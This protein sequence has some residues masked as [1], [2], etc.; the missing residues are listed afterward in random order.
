MPGAVKTVLVVDDTD[1]VR[2]V[3]EA[4]LQSLGFVTLGA[5]DGVVA[6]ELIRSV[7]PDVVLCDLRMPHMDGLELLAALRASHPDLPVIVMS[8]AGLLGDAIGALKLGAWDYVEKP[9]PALD[10]LEHA[11]ARA[12]ERAALL[13]E[14]RRQRDDLE[15]MNRELRATL[16]LLS[17]DEEAGRK[18]Q[19][20]L[21]PRNHVR[22][23]PF[24]FSL[25]LVPSAF[26]S[27]DFIDA[28]AIDDRRWG[29]YLA[30]VAGHGVSSALVTVL[31][32]TFVQRKVAELGRSG[33]TLVTSPAQ[34]L[35]SVNEEMSRQDLDTHMTLFYG[36]IDNA[37]AT[38]TYAN[39]GHFPWPLVWDGTR[40]TSLEHP[41]APLGMMPR[42]RWDEHQL[43][44]EEGTQLAAFSDGLLDVLPHDGIA[45]KQRFLRALFGRSGV[46]V[47]QIRRELRLDERAPLPDDVAMLLIK[48]GG[49]DGPDGPR[50]LGNG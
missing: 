37:S 10:I 24:E 34:L 33:D 8:G 4:Q 46:T 18:L 50:V 6:L 14:N 44:L 19:F 47:E 36:V 17:A 23:G 28:F 39:A 49:G 3:L 13:A 26:L 7:R 22:F 5:E 9:I 2:H 45:A 40:S 16:R 21:L 29:F 30:D 25:D 11:I 42:A 15:A 32:R 38:L 31:L 43:V 48:R 12:L 1:A 35:A 41:G 27:G 20:R